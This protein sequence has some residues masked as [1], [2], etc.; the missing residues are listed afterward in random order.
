MFLFK[1]GLNILVYE[2]EMFSFPAEFHFNNRHFSSDQIFF[3]SISVFLWYNFSLHQD[4][5]KNIVFN[6]LKPIPLSSTIY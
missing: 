6:T 3:F 5:S 4:I 1:V 2:N